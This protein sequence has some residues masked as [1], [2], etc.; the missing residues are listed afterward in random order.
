MI[1]RGK[2][3]KYEIYTLYAKN[4]WRYKGNKKVKQNLKKGD[5][6]TFNDLD[7]IIV[8]VDDSSFEN[9]T[10]HLDTPYEYDILIGTG[11]VYLR[12]LNGL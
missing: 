2:F 4:K 6:F 10:I 7:Y 11:K 9:I 8:S 12:L 3:M 5:I 1:N